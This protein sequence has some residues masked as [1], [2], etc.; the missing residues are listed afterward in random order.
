MRATRSSESSVVHSEIR[1]SSEPLSPLV[2]SL[3]GSFSAIVSRDLHYQAQRMGSH[4]PGVKQ[5]G[6]CSISVPL[7]QRPPKPLA[8]RSIA[9]ARSA[10]LV[11]PGS[12]RAVLG[13][14]RSGW[15][16]SSSGCRA[17]TR[18][19]P[20]CPTV[21]SAWQFRSA[22][23]SGN[24]QR[25]AVR[26]AHSQYGPVAWHGIGANQGGRLTA[27]ATP[28]WLNRSAPA[29]H[30][31]VHR[32]WQAVGL[33]R[34]G[35]S[36]LPSR[37][38]LRQVTYAN[39]RVAPLRRQASLSLGPSRTLA[40]QRVTVASVGSVATSV[41]IPWLAASGPGFVRAWRNSRIRRPTSGCN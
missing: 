28:V 14:L 33:P 40:S 24:R 25:R 19:R 3:S 10:A 32:Q 2:R 9:P 15:L 27:F 38:W 17:A 41:I 35:R 21:W 4:G 23:G 18:F 5:A 37:P 20:G 26:V 30:L 7:I 16:H 13:S 39:Y 11:W 12:T 31:G 6:T 36:L 34:V 8:S 1:A 29:G 22:A